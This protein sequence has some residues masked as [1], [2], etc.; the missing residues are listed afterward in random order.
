MERAVADPGRD[1]HEVEERGEREHDRPE[2]Q[3]PAPDLADDEDEAGEREQE[4]ERAV[5]GDE[6]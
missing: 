5:P 6:R 4:A 1:E 3:A 2:T